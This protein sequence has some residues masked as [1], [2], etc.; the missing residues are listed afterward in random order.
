MKKFIDK[1]HSLNWII[2]DYKTDLNNPLYR[3][4]LL[5]LN[6]EINSWQSPEISKFICNNFP[7]GE[8]LYCASKNQSNTTINNSMVQAFA[9][10]KDRLVGTATLSTNHNSLLQEEFNSDKP[11]LIINFLVVDPNST[12]KGIGTRMIGSINHNQDTFSNNTPTSGSVAWV[13][14]QNTASQRA[15]LK[16][17]FTIYHRLSN[18]NRQ[19]FYTTNNNPSSSDE[20]EQ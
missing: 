13:S 8:T 14:K 7:L 15:F 19:I 16:N 4:Q 11:Y 5:R 6:F 9:F 18:N 12:S 2:F 1:E 17:K 10:D 3:D 20:M